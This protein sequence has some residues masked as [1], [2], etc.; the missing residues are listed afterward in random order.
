MMIWNL[1][2]T[3]PH[4]CLLSR[5]G[6]VHR[7]TRFLRFLGQR[8]GGGTRGPG[9]ATRGCRG[10][11]DATAG[12]GGG[13]IQFLAVQVQKLIGL[14]F[15]GKSEPETIDFPMKIMGFSCRFDTQKQSIEKHGLNMGHIW[16]IYGLYW[17]DCAYGL[18]TEPAFCMFLCLSWG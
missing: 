2:P 16:T 13:D 7:A 17:V 6:G 1:F 9:G 4:D 5:L 15:T 10:D 8:P 11:G 18:K 14:V 12:A 3:F